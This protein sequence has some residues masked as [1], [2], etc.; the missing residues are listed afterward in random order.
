MCIKNNEKSHFTKDSRI[1]IDFLQF[2]GV[3]LRDSQDPHR[4]GYLGS[5]LSPFANAIYFASYFKSSGKPPCFRLETAYC[6]KLSARF[7][8]DLKV[9][10]SFEFGVNLKTNTKKETRSCRTY[11]STV[12]IRQ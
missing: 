4:G 6:G 3:I 2:Y 11:L 1:Q 9:K 8:Y 5:T 10:D 7:C 12:I